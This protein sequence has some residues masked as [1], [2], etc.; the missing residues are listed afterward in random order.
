ML[1]ALPVQTHHLHQTLDGRQFHFLSGPELHGHSIRRGKESRFQVDQ[2]QILPGP[3]VRAAIRPAVLTMGSTDA[4][5]WCRI[6]TLASVSGL[7]VIRP[8]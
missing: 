8:E 4:K 7:L 5:D 2:F 3:E 6:V 1:G